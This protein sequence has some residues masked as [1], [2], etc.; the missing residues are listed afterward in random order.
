MG[1][2]ERRIRT[3]VRAIT[4]LK[5]IARSRHIRGLMMGGLLLVLVHMV[6]TVGY[7]FIGRPVASWIDSFYM[8]FITVAT[9]GYGET[10]DLS[11]HPLG[12]L[13]TVGLP[14]WASAR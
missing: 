10:V 3:P 8:T 5:K 12:R 6:G 2:A 4:P 9:I 11:T 14:S 13:F 7:H 1:C